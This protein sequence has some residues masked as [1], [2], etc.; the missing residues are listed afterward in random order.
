M[1]LIHYKFWKIS[2]H[3]NASKSFKSSLWKKLEANLPQANLIA[4]AWFEP[5]FVRRLSGVVAG[6]VLVA[7]SLTNAYAYVSPEVAEGALL[8][9]LKQAWEK[10]EEATKITPAAEA[11]FYLKKLARREA[12]SAV[13]ER[14]QKKATKTKVQLEL[15]EQRLEVVTEK[16]EKDSDNANQKL[17]HDLRQRLIKRQKFLETKLNKLN[18]ARSK[19]FVSAVPA[20][21]KTLEKKLPD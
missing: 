19:N 6:L 17:G 16:L 21:H 18:K 20:T 12:E 2:R 13:L 1:R 7:T 14:R 8:Y 9:P 3:L 10:A 11:H 5:P 4:Y 15:I